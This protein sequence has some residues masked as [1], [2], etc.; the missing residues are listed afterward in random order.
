ME[1]IIRIADKLKAMALKT[2][3]DCTFEKTARYFEKEEKT[4]VL[5]PSGDEK[6][7]SFWVR[8]A[9]MMAESGLVSN[10]DLKRY[11][12]IIACCGQNGENAVRLKNDLEIPP[13]A[14]ADHINYDG[15][16]V[17]FPGTYSSGEDQGR[18]NFGFFPPFCDN[19]YFIIM[20]CQYIN[21]SGDY[22][23]LQNEYNGLSLLTRVEKAF[24]CYNIDDITG[25]CASDAQKYTVDWGFVDTVK[26]SGKLLMASLLRYNSG[27]MLSEVFGVIGQKEKQKILDAETQKIKKSIID[28]FY[29]AKT[30]WF[31]SATGLCRQYDVWATAYAVFLNIA[32]EDKTLEALWQGYR[33]KS[34]VVD[35]QIRHVLTTNNFSPESAWESAISKMNT[36]QNGA[37]WATPTGWYA[38]ALYKYNRRVDILDDFYAHYENYKDKGAPFEWIN[39]K[40]EIFSGLHYGTS[41]VLPYVGVSKIIN[42]MNSFI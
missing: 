4:R 29:D 18:G 34:A 38:Y 5:L 35:G 42:E 30:G 21:Q 12:E 11:V 10:A 17:F 31:Y 27:V 40:T 26:K 32:T 15:K 25:L 33:D 19:F 20:V 3:N 37:Y 23:I 6:Y 7:R 1:N 16:A 2:I 22:Q 13:F 8:D 39:D 28:T 36:Y 24:A 9:A 41:G 14:I